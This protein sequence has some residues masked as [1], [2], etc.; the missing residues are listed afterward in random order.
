M[1]TESKGAKRDAHKWKTQV[2]PRCSPSPS[3]Q[4]G[5]KGA[6]PSAQEVRPH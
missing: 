1:A 6:W 4:R 2:Q 5:A 3:G